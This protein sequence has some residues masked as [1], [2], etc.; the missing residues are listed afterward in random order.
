MDVVVADV[1][2][3]DLESIPK[4]RAG[5]L[6]RFFLV[7]FVLNSGF[8]G[9]AEGETRPWVPQP[10]TISGWVKKAN[11]LS[12]QADAVKPSVCFVGDSLTEFWGAEG[13]PIW[14]LEFYDKQVANLGM[15]ADRV[16][17]ILW[18]LKHGGLEKIRPKV[19]VLMLGTNNLSKSSPDKSAD[20]VRGIKEVLKLIHMKLP[21]SRI[22][23]VSI[24]PNGDDPDSELR[25]RIL[26]TNEALQKLSLSENVE[27]IDAHDAFLN[28]SGV[29]KQG[30]S[31]DGTHLTMRGYE[32]LMN[33]LREPLK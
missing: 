32:I 14:Q 7:L 3:T 11:R 5:F 2:V 28:A 15:A 10:G 6:A 25:K 8:A 26:Q 30:L 17:N 23:L 4:R 20:I 31:V 12:R 13:S 16:E 29:W 27:Y 9:G 19:F 22:L 1:V 24:L 18:R 21:E 33:Q